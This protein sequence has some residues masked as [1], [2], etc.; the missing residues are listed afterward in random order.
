MEPSADLEPHSPEPR[1]PQTTYLPYAT[2]ATN[3]Y[4][5]ALLYGQGGCRAH[6][7]VYFSPR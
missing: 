4:H 5:D 7:Q 1:T 2:R 6:L 3:A